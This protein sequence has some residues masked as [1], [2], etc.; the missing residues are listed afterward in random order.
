MCEFLSERSRN[1]EKWVRVIG[2]NTLRLEYER[3]DERN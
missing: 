2:I 1:K 3:R